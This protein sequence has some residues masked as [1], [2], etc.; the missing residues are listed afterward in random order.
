MTPE[1]K[2]WW[3]SLSTNEKILREELSYLKYKRSKEKERMSF[4]WNV[5]VKKIILERINCCTVYIRTIKHKL[6]STAVAVYA[7]YYDGA[8]PVYRCKKCG[9]TFGNFGQSYCCWCGR[10]MTR[11]KK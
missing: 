10:K 6:D 5:D 3:D 4:M 7:G 9:G 8:F 2:K 11:E 1:R